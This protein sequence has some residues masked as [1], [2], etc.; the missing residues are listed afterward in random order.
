MSVPVASKVLR[1]APAVRNPKK[2]GGG[3]K[4]C[5]FWEKH[6]NE[7]D[8]ETRWGQDIVCRNIHVRSEHFSICLFH[9][10]GFVTTVENAKRE[11]TSCWIDEE[12]R[13]KRGIFLWMFNWDL[14]RD[15]IKQARGGNFPEDLVLRLPWVEEPLEASTEFEWRKSMAAMEFLFASDHRLWCRKQRPTIVVCRAKE[16]RTLVDQGWA[17]LM[18]KLKEGEAGDANG[19]AQFQESDSTT[20]SNV[21]EGPELQAKD[22]NSGTD[23]VADATVGDDGGDAATESTTTT[24]TTVSNS[25]T[26]TTTTTVT[27]VAGGGTTTNTTTTTLTKRKNQTQA[28]S[29]DGGNNKRHRWNTA[30]AERNKA[31]IDLE[32]EK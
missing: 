12:H 20:D 10:W 27:T 3:W 17:A 5:Q 9:D 26:T 30:R 24:T 32:Q 11:W 22:A 16:F 2:R 14:F 18:S 21:L 6:E 7:E 1:Q 19:E 28:E 15:S 29:R 8:G 13:K 31:T 23:N 25:S 4:E